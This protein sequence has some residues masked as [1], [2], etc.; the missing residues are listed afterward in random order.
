VKKLVFN[1]IQP[2][3]LVV[4]VLLWVLVPK[5]LADSSR[6]IVVASPLTTPFV[7]A[8]EFSNARPVSR[9]LN[10]REFFTDLFY[11]VLVSSVIAK[12]ATKLAPARG[13]PVE[14]HLVDRLVWSDQ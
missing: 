8:L 9:R 7:L 2:L 10:R 13:L 11:V 4:I 6:T 12:V 14:R 5:S 3:T 1:R